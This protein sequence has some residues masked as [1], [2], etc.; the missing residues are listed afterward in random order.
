MH[1][2]SLQLQL[3]VFWEFSSSRELDLKIL[4]E[5]LAKEAAD[6]A[7]EMAARQK[8]AGDMRRYREQL[9][10]MMQQEA[11]EDAERDAL[12]QEVFEEQQRKRD[13]EL[14]AREEARRR[15]MAEVDAIRQQQIQYKQMQ[16]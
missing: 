2:G 13:A 7:K 9:A 3:T 8:R 14:A 6:E 4:Q 16:R 11:D 1:I 5:A 10:I 12:I 15:L